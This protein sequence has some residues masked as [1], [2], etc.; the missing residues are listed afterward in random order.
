MHHSLIHAIHTRHPSASS[1]VRLAHRWVA[2]HMLSDMIPHEAIELMVARI[3][4]ET[5]GK[6]NGLVD[7]P[8]STAV[9]GFLRFLQ[10]LSTHDWVRY[11][12]SFMCLFPCF[13]IETITYT[14]TFH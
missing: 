7:T 2:S 10:L 12:M 8:P 13:K 14:L 4:T 5:S 11:E 3:Y 1:V 6:S 9:A